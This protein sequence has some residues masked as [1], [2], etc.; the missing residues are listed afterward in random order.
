MC[1][2]DSFF[3]TV[4][5]KQ[6]YEDLERLQTDLFLNYSTNIIPQKVKTTPVEV[7]FDIALNQIIDLVSLL[8]QRSCSILV[9]TG[10]LNVRATLQS[11]RWMPN[12]FELYRENSRV[13]FLKYS[14]YIVSYLQP[15]SFS[16][17]TSTLQQTK[18]NLQK[19]W[20]FSL[21]RVF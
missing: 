7:K 1:I 8:V 12:L 18:I 6:Y 19:R 9:Y 21:F 20:H 13:A 15:L 3:S 2:R 10:F 11:A 4:G 16:E 5:T 14:C 17:S